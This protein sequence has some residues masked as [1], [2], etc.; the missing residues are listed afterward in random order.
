MNSTSA[1]EV[2]SQPLWPGPGLSPSG[3]TL[4]SGA[5]LTTYA[6]RLASRCS[7]VAAGAAAAAAAAGASSAYAA[8][9]GLPSATKIAAIVS[10][11]RTV[12][13]KIRRARM[14]LLAK[15]VT[16]IDNKRYRAQVSSVY[17]AGKLETLP[18]DPRAR[19]EIGREGALARVVCYAVS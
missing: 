15:Y 5:L 6:S 9:S 10:R 3:S 14:A 16:D 18:P 7:I 11:P 19:T 1:L 17:R 8:R 13:R 2:I 4:G 12:A